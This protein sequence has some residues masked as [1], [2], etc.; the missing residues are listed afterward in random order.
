[1]R[2][3]ARALARRAANRYIVGPELDDAI[4][5]CRHLAEQGIPTTICAWNDEHG[6]AEANAERCR[7]GIDAVASERL[8]CYVSL[9]ALDVEFSPRLLELIAAHARQ[10]GVG[11]HFDSMG[12]EAADETL[13]VVQRLSEAGGKLGC[14]IPGRWRRSLADAERAAALGARIR[15]VKGQWSDPHEPKTDPSAGFRR[16]IDHI[17]GKARH[18]AVATHDPS[19]SKAALSRLRESCTSCE[20]ELLFGLPL[21]KSFDIARDLKV[22]VRIYLPYGHPWLPYALRQAKRH[23]VIALRALRD[24]F[25]GRDLL[26]GAEFR[27]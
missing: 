24:A 2:D 14:T 15:V 6:S 10:H 19:L 27:L 7:L 3:F 8:D 4:G 20:L 18:V 1:M 23:P 21:G 22:P 13:S 12:P 11:L 5:K 17:A 9:K 16:V 26:A 25:A